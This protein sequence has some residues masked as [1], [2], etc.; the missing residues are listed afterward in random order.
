VIKNSNEKISEVPLRFSNIIQNHLFSLDLKN[1]LKNTA[2][3]KI[4]AWI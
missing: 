3:E 4:H 1:L 2:S